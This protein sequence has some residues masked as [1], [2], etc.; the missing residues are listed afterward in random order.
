MN[1]EKIRRM[2]KL[3][4]RKLSE[5][6]ITR[7]RRVKDVLG[8]S[9]TDAIWD[10]LTAME[11]QRFYYDELP[12]KIAGVSAEILKKLGTA[13]GNGAS[14]LRLSTVSRSD[15]AALLPLAFTFLAALLFYGSLLLWAGFCIGSGRAHPPELLLRIPSGLI[16]GGLCLMGGVLLGVRAAKNFAEEEKDWRKPMLAALVLLLLGGVVVS[17]A[18]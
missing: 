8:I 11:Y 9:D 15:T 7:L 5:E 1:A 3:L 18:L 6:E 13:Q 16:M 2:E 12:Q 4:D 14:P 10:V 17:L